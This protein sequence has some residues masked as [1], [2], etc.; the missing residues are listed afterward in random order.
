MGDA[1]MV[2][3]LE[4]IKQTEDINLLTGYCAM[5]LNR[6][7][8]AKTHFAKSSNPQVRKGLT[9]LLLLFRASKIRNFLDCFRILWRG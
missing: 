7:D 2:F 9:W 5:L 3:A 1:G 6:M 4:E 8:E